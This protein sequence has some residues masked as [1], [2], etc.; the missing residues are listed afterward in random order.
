MLAPL[1]RM[2]TAAAGFEAVA[3]DL[4]LYGPTN[5]AARS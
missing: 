1:C 5:G 2:V 4:S 3:P